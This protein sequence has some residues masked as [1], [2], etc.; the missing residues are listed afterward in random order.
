[1]KRILSFLLALILVVS[2]IPLPFNVMAASEE[3]VELPDYSDLTVN[4]YISKILLNYN[5]NGC[6][7]AEKTIRQIELEDF[8]NQEN[9]S[10]SNYLVSMLKDNNAFMFSVAT[11]EYLTFNP[12]NITEDMLNEKGYYTAIILNILNAQMNNSVILDNL[13]ND[14]GKMQL[15]VNKSIISILK[16]CNGVDIKEN[17]LKNFNLSSLSSSEK[18]DLM[19]KIAK[20][21]INKDY[22]NYL[23]QGFSFVT[24]ALGVCTTAKEISDTICSYIMISQLGQEMEDVLYA[25]YVNCPQSNMA[26]K[27][28]LKDVYEACSSDF[29][30]AIVS[31]GE[32]GKQIASYAFSKI[33]GEAWNACI[34]GIAG[35]FVGGLLIGQVIGKSISNFCFSS[36]KVA[37]QY[38][39]MNAMIEFE[40]LMIETVG[41]MGDAFKNTESVSAADNYIQS[42][43]LLFSTYLLDCDYAYDFVDTVQNGNLFVSPNN[44]TVAVYKETA[45]SR[46]TNFNFMCRK[47]TTIAGYLDYYEL[48]APSAF[49]ALFIKVF[50]YIK[51][52]K[53]IEDYYSNLLE[54]NYFGIWVWNESSGNPLLCSIGLWNSWVEVSEGWETAGRHIGRKYS[55]G[56]YCYILPENSNYSFNFE[57][58]LKEFSD[59]YVLNGQSYYLGY[60][61]EN[62]WV[63]GN[64]K[65]EV[66]ELLIYTSVKNDQ[67]VVDSTLPLHIE[68]ENFA[69]QSGV[70][71]ASKVYEDSQFINSIGNGDSVTYDVN[72]PDTGYYTLSLRASTT[73]LGSRAAEVYIDGVYKTK[74]AISSTGAWATFNTF[75][76]EEIYLT[77]GSH[78]VTLKA[79]GGGYNL[80]WL[81]FVR[82]EA[83]DETQSGDDSEV[84]IHIEAEDYDTM[85]GVELRGTYDQGT[86]VL[87]SVDKGDY[88]VYSVNIPVSGTY[89]FDV[90]AAKKETGTSVLSL[91]ENGKV[92]SSINITQTGSWETYS[93]FEGSEMTLTAGTH[94]FTVYADG[95]RYNLNWFELTSISLDSTQTSTVENNTSGITIYFYGSDWSS[96]YLWSWDGYD[97]LTWPGDAFTKVNGTN[98][99][100]KLTVSAETLTGYIQETSQGMGCDNSFGTISGYGTYFI[101]YNNEVETLYTSQSQAESVASEAINGGSVSSPETPTQAPTEAP[102]QA[103]TQALVT[104]DSIHIEAED[105][106]SQSGVALRGIYDQ[107]TDVL[108]SVDAGDYMVYSVN[109]PVSGSYRF[110]VRAA[111]SDTGSSLLSLMENEQVIATVSVGRTG[112]WSTFSEFT[113]TEVY[114]TAGQH[115]FKVY[116]DGGRYNLNWYK[117]TS[118]SADGGETPTQA[119][120]EAL[121]TGE[122]IHIEAEDFTSQSG[123]ALRGIYDQGTDVLKSVDAGDYMVYSVNVPVSGVYR[124]DVRAA[125]SDAGSS[126]LS[127]MEN[128]AVIATVSVG[129]T[130]GWSNFSEFT[131]TEV[132][133]TAGQHTFT[134]Y[135]D[136]GRYNLNWYELTS[137]SV[138]LTENSTVENNTSGITIYF[139]GSDWSSAYLW[140]WDGYDTLTWPGDTFTKV[141]GT[142]N[143]WKLT[144]NAS[145]LTG[146]IQETGHG[147]GCDAQFGTISGYGTYF[148][149]YNNEVE[150]LYTSQSQAESAAG[151]TINGGSV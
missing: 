53:P 145:E 56:W 21:D 124:F 83:E 65:A 126:L 112:G 33:V 66:N 137:L 108:K 128:N 16:E 140:S 39:V 144:V 148:I 34:K 69:N 80:N 84:T 13:N 104:G 79:V 147:I 63:K 11:W 58:K 37:E 14:F 45:N 23:G 87:K 118:I 17:E 62:G 54:A 30:A 94:T 111:R 29:K 96:A 49:E 110:D 31:M 19:A 12:S 127:L 72:I 142:D 95:G 42:V 120:T 35:G 90:R 1:M 113:G 130:G 68:A 48:D 77:E 106:V 149:V 86:D 3:E 70:E 55:D 134:V 151:E 135:A 10:M 28:A 22:L 47:L 117:L 102:T 74:I 52:E 116:A 8:F 71:I 64:S 26:M 46:K 125:R 92:I 143:W 138:E 15:S 133:L 97:T 32:T 146:Y 24:D 115:T 60:S 129:R 51:D 43:K 7:A 50:C 136:G 2:V 82:N 61:E 9:K 103:P 73:Y 89:R 78:S 27:S 36:N 93:E 139:Y 105:F 122:N 91:R 114:L 150:T 67:E 25:L 40:A 101:V 75:E 88:M 38:Y 119:P 5:Y 18:T 59:D 81:E 107:G 98:N 141:N 132:H 85:K 57:G 41:T 121:V 123:V 76:S 6:I 20:D 4:Q 99:W 44:E 100:W 131:G 109:V